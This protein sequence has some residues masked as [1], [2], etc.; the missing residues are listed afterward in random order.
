MREC[1][2]EI[3]R[4]FF[5]RQGLKQTAQNKVGC[6]EWKSKL[7]SAVSGHGGWT[8]GSICLELESGRYV[9]LGSGNR[10]AF[11]ERQAPQ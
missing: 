10:K 9:L 7:G 8:A 3:S 2:G 5:G 1:E 6:G 11:T 4:A